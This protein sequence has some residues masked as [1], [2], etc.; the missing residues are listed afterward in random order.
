MAVMWLTEANNVPAEVQCRE[1]RQLQ[2]TRP[3]LLGGTD[4]SDKTWPA[5]AS[6]GVP[7]HPIKTDDVM[8][9]APG[10][11][12]LERCV[13]SMST[14]RCHLLAGVHTE[15]VVVGAGR[16]VPLEITGEGARSI[17]SGTRMLKTKGGSFFN[18]K[19]HMHKTCFYCS[20]S[21]F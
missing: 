4:R 16:D 6:C 8:M 7:R 17:L 21:V 12:E 19:K 15:S 13:A 11:R 20:S 9:I 3:W 10:G 1:L 2:S 14:R 5:N 18:H